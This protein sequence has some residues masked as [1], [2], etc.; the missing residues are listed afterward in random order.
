MSFETVP[1]API[2]TDSYS[3]QF[4]D[5]FKLALQF[6]VVLNFFFLLPFHSDVKCTSNVK[7][8]HFRSILSNTTMSG[9]LCSTLLSVCILK[10]H[11]SLFMYWIHTLVV[12]RGCNI[13]H[14]CHNPAFH[15]G[16][17]ES[18]APLCRASNIDIAF[19]QVSCIPI[20]YDYSSHHFLCT[21]YTLQTHFTCQL[22]CLYY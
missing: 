6:L 22:S 13:F 21:F 5:P 20:Q 2:M 7:I 8:R 9:L 18:P 16:T 11:S 4:P 3:A 12:A 19:E 14:P 15:I 10:S 17:S 1:N